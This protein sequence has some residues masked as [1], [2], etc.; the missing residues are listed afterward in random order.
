MRWGRFRPTRRGAFAAGFAVM[1]LLAGF[2]FVWRG[3]GSRLSAA[4]DR[5]GELR[6]SIARVHERISETNR[7]FLQGE[8]GER[9]RT[10]FES[11]VTLASCFD[12]VLEEIGR[13][14]GEGSLLLRSVSVSPPELDPDLERIS[15][16]MDVDGTYPSLTTWFRW[17]EDAYPVFHVN[18]FDFESGSAPGTVRAHLRGALYL[19]TGGTEAAS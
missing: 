11:D 10:L 12:G 4:L 13:R 7:S 14:A 15:F 16:E 6:R 2:S 18:G 19:P 17:I 1:I 9:L 5:R 3:P 8:D